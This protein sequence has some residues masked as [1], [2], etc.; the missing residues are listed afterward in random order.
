MHGWEDWDAG[1]VVDWA[2]RIT[3]FPDKTVSVW[4]MACGTLVLPA[5]EPSAWTRARPKLKN[6]A[7]PSRFAAENPDVSDK[8]RGGHPGNSS[9]MPSARARWPTVAP[10]ATS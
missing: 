9:W 1:W 7:M 5:V 6:A 10:S 3:R 4:D 8:S 2:G